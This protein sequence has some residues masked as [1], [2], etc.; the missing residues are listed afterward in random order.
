MKQ[1]TKPDTGLVSQACS[2]KTCL[3][4]FVQ[5]SQTPP[6]ACRSRGLHDVV[7]AEIETTR[8]IYATGCLRSCGN[9]FKQR[10]VGKAPTSASIDA[11][12]SGD[13]RLSSFQLSRVCACTK[14]VPRLAH[15]YLLSFDYHVI[16]HPSSSCSAHWAVFSYHYPYDLLTRSSLFLC[17]A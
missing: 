11:W 5:P 9:K 13:R 14:H 17:P 15:A 4:E 2:A 6:I 3:G 12:L 8:A 7:M 1:E 16:L 10:Q